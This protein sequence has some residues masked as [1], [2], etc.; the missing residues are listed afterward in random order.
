MDAGEGFLGMLQDE[1]KPCLV[2]ERPTV[3]S[4][5]NRSLEIVK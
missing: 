5:Y 3:I 2:L 4:S 1:T